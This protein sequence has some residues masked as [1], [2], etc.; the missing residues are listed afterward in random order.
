MLRNLFAIVVFLLPFAGC[1]DRHQPEVRRGGGEIRESAGKQS[2]ASESGAPRTENPHRNLLESPHS[3]TAGEQPEE[4][5]GPVVDLGSLTLTAPKEWPRKPP[6]SGVLL[7]EFSLP[8]A[9]GDPSDGRLTVSGVGGG[10]QANI[11]RWKGQFSGSPKTAEEHLKAAGRD[12]TLVDFTGTYKDQQGMM[13]PVTERPDYRLLGAI[14]ATG[15]GR[16]V[17]VVKA[18]GPLKTMG[19]HAAEFRK[20]VESLETKTGP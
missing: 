16:N 20:F 8:H 4:T 14:I 12:V 7:A 18:Y 15:E 5:L 2:P 17:L 19:A 9:E 6:R 11:D 10:V 13:G 3:E 1:S